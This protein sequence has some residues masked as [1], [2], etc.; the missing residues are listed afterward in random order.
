MPK[1]LRTGY[2]TLLV[3][4]LGWGLCVFTRIDEAHI[5]LMKLISRESFLVVTRWHVCLSRSR[6]L[7]Q[8]YPGRK[9]GRP[10]SLSA[11]DAA[12]LV[13]EALRLGAHISLWTLHA[14]AASSA[15]AARIEC[16][17]IDQAIVGGASYCKSDSLVLFSAAQ[18]VMLDLPFRERRRW[19]VTAEATSH[20]Y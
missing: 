13:R 7:C 20:L 9:E 4:V 18:S 1:H 14:S 5:S 12:R 8:R 6:R 11:L 15:I 17:S 2:V 19:L 16:R 3:E 10:I